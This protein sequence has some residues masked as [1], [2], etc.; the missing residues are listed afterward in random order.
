MLTNLRIQVTAMQEAAGIES[1]SHHA[2]QYA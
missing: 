2:F 1:Y